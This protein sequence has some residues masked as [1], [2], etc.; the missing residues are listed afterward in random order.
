MKRGQNRDDDFGLGDQRN[1]AE[2][3]ATRTS[4]S[5][6]VVDALE[7]RT[8]IDARLVRDSDLGRRE[9]CGLPSCTGSTTFDRPR[10]REGC[11]AVRVG[12]AARPFTAKL[13]PWPPRCQAS[14]R[15]RGPRRGVAKTNAERRRR[16]SA[17]ADD[18]GVGSGRRGA[19]KTEPGSCFR[20]ESFIERSDALL[21]ASA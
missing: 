9:D 4:Q 10:R 21:V 7:Q 6:D 11:V 2:A 17:P 5:V 19:P 18:A 14:S 1:D 16:G 15:A 13:G 12:V 20:I 8:P 3:P